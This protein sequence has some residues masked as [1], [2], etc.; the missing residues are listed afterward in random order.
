MIN[1]C[2]QLGQNDLNRLKKH[3]YSQINNL[4]NSE[5]FCLKKFIQKYKELKGYIG[6]KNK[7]NFLRIID[8]IKEIHFSLSSL[9]HSDEELVDMMSNE[10]TRIEKESL[11]LVNSIK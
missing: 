2:R 5:K 4:L 1:Q 10:I 11:R 6:G 3:G 9:Y 8:Q 7:K